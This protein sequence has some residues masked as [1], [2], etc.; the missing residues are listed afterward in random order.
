MTKAEFKRMG[1]YREGLN[2]KLTEVEIKRV[3]AYTRS[4]C[5]Y[6]QKDRKPKGNKSKKEGGE[7]GT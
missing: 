6:R 3:E 7:Y 1:E 2:R 4:L 5:I